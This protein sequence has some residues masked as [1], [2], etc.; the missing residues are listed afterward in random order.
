[1]HVPKEACVPVYEAVMKEGAKHGICN[2]GY[3]AIDSLSIEK[4]YRHW[5]ADLRPDDTPLESVL[6]FTCKLKT[7]IPFLG[8]EAI[9]KQKAEGLKKKL[10]CFTIDDHVP[11]HGLEAIWRDDVCVGF[12]RRADYAFAL[13]KS[14]GYGYVNHP[15]KTKITNDWLRAGTYRL[16]N[17]GNSYD[18]K[19]HIQT[20]FDPK[21]KR[22]KGIY[23]D[24]IPI[25]Q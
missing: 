23:E 16:E 22:V 13:G 25:R 12:I 9:E 14:I 21:N 4:G 2:A 11:L 20:P 18:A 6:G 7:P 10:A 24:P 8:R 15:D 1:L 17:M 19:I 5:H 3:R